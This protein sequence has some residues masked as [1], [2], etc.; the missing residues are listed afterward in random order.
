MA[1]KNL[2]PVKRL[3]VLKRLRIISYIENN[4]YAY[5]LSQCVPCNITCTNNNN[6]DEQSDL[7]LRINEV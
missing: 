7:I 4:V 2:L 5:A 1:L 3:T 6:N